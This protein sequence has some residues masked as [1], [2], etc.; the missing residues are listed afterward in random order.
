MEITIKKKIGGWI[1]EYK[2]CGKKNGEYIKEN[3]KEIQLIEELGEVIC[4]Y[5]VK[6]V[7]Q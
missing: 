1:V 3:T 4:E 6:V 7:R 5:K 2:D